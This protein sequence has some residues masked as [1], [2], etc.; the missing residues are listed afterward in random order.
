MRT[1]RKAIVGGLLLLCGGGL[2]QGQAPS[3]AVGAG[4]SQP[5]AL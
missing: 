3:P 4:A 2:I 1:W 5:T